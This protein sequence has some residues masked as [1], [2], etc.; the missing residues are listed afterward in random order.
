MAVMRRRGH[1]ERES[2]IFQPVR[3]DFPSKYAFRARFS[4]LLLSLTSPSGRKYIAHVV[5]LGDSSV[6]AG[7]R[8]VTE[9][10]KKEV[11]IL[12]EVLVRQ[13]SL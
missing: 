1:G 6:G 10:R 2:I 5:K 8:G 4:H 7:I 13:H 11:L 12:V 9:S 3:E